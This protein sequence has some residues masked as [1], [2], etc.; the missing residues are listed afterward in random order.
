MLQSIELVHRL[1]IVEVIPLI[2][3]WLDISTC[4]QFSTHGIKIA[5][6]RLTIP[7]RLERVLYVQS[8]CFSSEFLWFPHQPVN[9][10]FGEPVVVWNCVLLLVN[11]MWGRFSK[12]QVPRAGFGQERHG[13]K[14]W[15][16]LRR[17]SML[18]SPWKVWIFSAE[19]REAVENHIDLYK[20]VETVEASL[21]SITNM[22]LLC[23]FLFLN[24]YFQI[25]PVC[26]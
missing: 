22:F 4:T 7:K 14:A 8:S 23:F 17:K 20:C 3:N 5:P 15:P 16:Q 2:W 1:L 21:E 6:N 18:D 26:G 11:L 13:L 19:I 25:F 24:C 9:P 10:I 12:C